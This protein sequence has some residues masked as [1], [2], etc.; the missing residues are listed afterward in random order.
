[1][2]IGNRRALE[3]IIRL[4]GDCLRS[5]ICCTCPFSKEC[6]IDFLSNKP[7]SNNKRV[8]MALDR[9]FRLEIMEDDDEIS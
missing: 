8:D 3:E 7:W 6:L 5:D 2:K 9:L 4:D 1:M